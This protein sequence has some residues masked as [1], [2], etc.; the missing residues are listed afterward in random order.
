MRGGMRVRLAMWTCWLA[1]CLVAGERSVEI[2]DFEGANPLLGWTVSHDSQ[3]S[4][5]TGRLVIGSGH[6]GRGAV[7]EYQFRC[8]EGPSCRDAIL[9]TW[10]PSAPVAVKRK[11]ALSLWI[12][13]AP[14]VKIT[15]LVRDKSEGTK[16]YP[17]EATTLEHQVEGDWRHVVVPLAAKSTGYWDEDHTGRPEGRL[18][19]IGILAESRYPRPIRGSVRFDDVQILESPDQTFA[20]RVDLPLLQPS[21]PGSEQLGSRLGVSIHT[22][23]DD[24][25][26]DTAREAGFSFV[27]ADMLWRQVERNGRYRFQAH[28]RLMGA[29]DARHMGALWILDYGHPQHGGDP[30]RN[31]EDVAAFARYAGAVAAHF[32]GR[33]VRYEVWNEPNT[34]RFWKPEPN[35]KEYDALLKEATTAIHRADPAARVASGVL[36]RIDLPFLA[37]MIAAGG[38]TEINAAAVHPYRRQAPES[39]APELPLLRRLHPG[40]TGEKA[41]IWDTEWG[42]ASYDYFSKNLKGDGHSAAGRKRQAVLACREALTVWSLGLPVAVWYDLRDDGDD[43]SNPEHNYG[44]LDLHG[45][46]KPAMIAFR[47]LTRIAADH[48][49]AGMVLDVPDGAH[50]MRLDGS[51]DN[52]FAVWSDQPDS[53]ITVRF[54]GE[55]FASATNLLGEPL[56]MKESG[57]KDVEITLAETEGPVYI[58]FRLR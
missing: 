34:E 28:D 19:A 30:P 25:L 31:P 8:A 51:E 6:A 45:A 11:G 47:T 10:T 17:F 3:L 4:G 7:L 41:E 21:P 29:L 32:K 40:G 15:L 5:A 23:G 22:L 57:H 49:F 46:E 13:A 1:G 55:G 53:R 35:A 48:T 38:T 24:K 42:Y 12:R 2:A 18:S 26:L 9:A 52:V 50:A 58:K 37:G 54:S 33:N 20:L 36:G 16:R 44:L 56:K 27:R 39:F 14:E 43:P